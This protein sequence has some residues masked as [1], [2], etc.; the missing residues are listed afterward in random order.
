VIRTFFAALAALLLPASALAQTPSLDF[1]GRTV[2]MIIGFPSGGGTDQAGRMIGQFLAKYMPGQ[3]DLIVR[4]VPG[5]DGLTASNYFVQQVKPDGLTIMMA[6]S[7]T[8]DPIHFRKPE[9][10]YDPSKFGIIGGVGR[11]GSIM[12]ISKDAL[13]RLYDRSKPPVIMGTPAGVPKAGNLMTTWGIEYLGW[14]AKWVTGYK[15]TQDLAIALERG[16]IE[17]VSTSNMSE[18]QRMTEGGKAQMFAQ[19]GTI[20]NGKY[21]PRS[22]AP[23]VPVFSDM[24]EGKITDPLAL[25]AFAYYQALS[26]MDKWLVV[27]PDTPA[28]ITQ[29]YRA[30]YEKVSKDPEFFERGRRL[31]DDFEVRAVSDVELLVRTLWSTPSNALGHVNTLLKKQGI[32][33]D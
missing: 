33:I 1:K 14:N 2:T 21:A 12:V 3:P 29:V 8:S 20:L 17:M 19:S 24:M 10:K 5:A 32:G 15:G 9:A 31:S 27:P 28:E 18:V 4:N 13:T 6:S 7:S 16:E 23:S 22:D 11:G 25:K 30:A 26:A